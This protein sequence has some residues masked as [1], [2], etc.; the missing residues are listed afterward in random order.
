MVAMLAI[1]ASDPV[2]DRAVAVDTVS[3]YM[4]IDCLCPQDTAKTSR[5]SALVDGRR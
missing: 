5:G 4:H 1:V 2:F 3:A